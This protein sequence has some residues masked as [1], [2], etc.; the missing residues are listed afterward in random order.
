MATNFDSDEFMNKLAEAAARISQEADPLIAAEKKMAEEAEKNSK[1]LKAFGGALG[2]SVAELS[3]AAIQVKDGAGK[4]AGGI[5]SAGNAVR[6]FSKNFGLLGEAAG[7]L[8]QAFTKLVGG[9]LRQNDALIKSYRGLSNFGD[10][11]KTFKDIMQDMHDAG[12]SVDQNAETYVKALEKAAP[13]LAQFSGTVAK[14]REQLQKV[15]IDQLGQ[16]EYH[17]QRYGYSQEDMFDKT[18]NFMGILAA[19]GNNRKRQDGELTQLTKVYLDQLTLLGQITGQTREE[20]EKKLQRDAND[21]RFQMFLKNLPEDEALNLRTAMAS[22]PDEMADGAKSVIVNQGRIVDEQGAAF[23][24]LLGNEGIAELQKVIKTQGDKFPEAF[25]GTMNKYSG[26]IEKRFGQLGNNVAF[27]NDTMKSFMLTMGSFNLMN[28]GRL[29][30]EKDIA[31]A[32]KRLDDKSMKNDIDDATKRGKRE[33]GMRNAFESFELSMADMVLPALDAFQQALETLGAALAEF[34]YVV[35]FKKIDI[36]DAFKQFNTMADVVGTLTTEQEKQTKL[37]EELNSLTKTNTQNEKDIAD[38]EEKKRLGD[39][40]SNVENRLS[41]A[42]RYRKEH[43][44]RISDVT[45]K[46]ES[47]KRLTSK[48]QRYGKQLYEPDT[49]NTG[50]GS[51][52]MEGLKLK[53]G[54]DGAMREGGTV[55]PKLVELARL[56][57]AQVPGFNRFTSMD[58][59][60]H[61]G[62]NNSLHSKGK[63]LDFTIDHYPSPEEAAIIIS[64]L[65]EMGFN[66]VLDE[67][68]NPSASA[69]SKARAKGLSGPAGHFHA[70]LQA[71]NG[72]IFSGPVTGYNVKLHGDEMV[73]PVS[74]GVSKQP[75]SSGSLF[76]DSSVLEVF[77]L[78]VDKV[79][80]LV[81]LQ[82][83]NNSTQDELL[84]HSKT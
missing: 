61:A 6:G 8:T 80:T 77:Q 70:E 60:A 5:E 40:S 41:E 30:T 52:S 3:K 23:F 7:M 12:F 28:K 50:V 67:Y 75:L 20:A 37:T 68:N 82:R 11:G 45:G 48:A 15:M 57:Q 79:D 72:G 19:S 49:S 26:I 33:R 47:S 63:A 59:L 76:S 73:T 62:D 18:A 24:Q 21:L 34:A 55:D 35:S 1:A 42:Y 2:S 44:E 71:K 78:L 46:L 81:D 56:I 4:Y 17:L 53:M 10:V 38:L 29:V 27:G 69:I 58:D 36:R 25:A 43:Q 14:G 74:K 51:G 16:A 32:R 22:L 66:K 31:D 83:A 9:A 65:K 13:G 39:K 84:S 54:P 64:K